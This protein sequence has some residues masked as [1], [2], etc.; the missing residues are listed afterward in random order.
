LHYH[1]T[2]NLILQKVNCSVRSAIYFFILI[3]VTCFNFTKETAIVH[4]LVVQPTSS[5]IINGKTNVNSFQC[6]INKYSGVDTLVLRQ[7]SPGVKPFFTQ[8]AVSLAAATFDCG[9]NIMTKDFL[10]TINATKY[11][12][13]VI[14]FISFEKLPRYQPKEERFKTN[15][16]ISLAS[17][18]RNFEVTCSITKDEAGYVHLKGGKDFNFSDFGLKPPSR[19]AGAVKV[20]EKIEVNFHLILLRK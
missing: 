5:V 15:M 3:S 12:N 19:M 20:K 16:K 8:G 9:M 10:K 13:I 14:E 17:I 7:E 4:R 1:L 11:P 18:D 6:A 2:F